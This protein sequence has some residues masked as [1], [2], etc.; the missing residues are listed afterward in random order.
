MEVALPQAID[1]GELRL[2]YQPIVSLPTGKITGFEALVRWLHPERGLLS[3]A[4]FIPVAEQTQQIIPIT[5]WVLQEAC[6]QAGIWQARFPAGSPATISVNLPVV[7]LQNQDRLEEIYALILENGLIP[8]TLGLEL[9]EDQMMGD[10]KSVPR[11]LAYLDNF[12]V[13]LY[14][15]KFGMGFSSLNVLAHLPIRGLKIDRSFVADLYGP[16]KA[17]AIVKSV[18]SLGHSLE[19]DVIAVGVETLQQRDFLQ[20][21]KCQYAQGNHFSPPVDNEAAVGLLVRGVL[22]GGEK[23]VEVSRLRSFGLFAGLSDEDLTEIAYSCQELSV[24][25]GTVIFRQGQVGNEVYLLEEGSVSVYREQ[26]ETY[27]SLAV[28]EAPTV[29]GE[30]AIVNPERIRTGSVK[31]L[32]DLRLLTI[33]RG[34]FLSY[35]R[36]F[37]TL[38]NRLQQLI[39]GRSSARY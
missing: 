1:R 4:E 23:R 33:P 32:T 27:Q 34:G 16:G 17:A 22:T 28:L 35:L 37:P 11:S 9:T 31:A 2:H 5:Q 6:K 8:H 7:Y 29:F 13:S 36:R 38:K 21:V 24:P 3:P 18:L 25:S 15:D 12:G 26:Q 20:S 19:L 14:V 10:A 39:A 30:M